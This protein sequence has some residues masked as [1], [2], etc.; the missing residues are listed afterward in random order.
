[1]AAA[2]PSDTELEER[3]DCDSTFDNVEEI[4]LEEKQWGYVLE[5]L[6]EE[7]G[8]H[9]ELEED[10]KSK[11]LGA[12]ENILN[13][14]DNL[15][16]LDLENFDT[17]YFNYF[18]IE[19]SK[20]DTSGID[21]SSRFSSQNQEDE[22][23]VN[24]DNTVLSQFSGLSLN[25]NESL[26]IP[27]ENMSRAEKNYK[28]GKEEELDFGSTAEYVFTKEEVEKFDTSYSN[29]SFT[30]EVK[31]KLLWDGKDITK[32]I[33]KSKIRSG[34]IWESVPRD[35]LLIEVEAQVRAL[36]CCRD[37]SKQIFLKLQEK[38]KEDLPFFSD[39][40]LS[41]LGCQGDEVTIL[42]S[43]LDSSDGAWAMVRPKGPILQASK[44]DTIE[45]TVKFYKEDFQKTEPMKFRWGKDS[46]LEPLESYL[47]GNLILKNEGEKLFIHVQ[48]PALPGGWAYFYSFMTPKQLRLSK[49]SVI[50]CVG[51]K[52]PYQTYGSVSFEGF[53]REKEER[54]GRQKSRELD[55]VSVKLVWSP[56]LVECQLAMAE[57][58]SVCFS[59][60]LDKSLLELESFLR[61]HFRYSSESRLVGFNAYMSEFRPFGPRGP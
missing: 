61:T 50:F 51:L 59:W 27:K 14:L 49:S 15:D 33:P 28:D 54:F 45:I 18:N 38:D 43:A 60:D 41:R 19:N 13:N 17:D 21:F 2:C 57:A 52:P 4:G 26:H 35:G 20:M 30:K 22:Y 46:V 10:W 53:R 6:G 31:I 29:I 47:R 8:R 58:R 5:E 44:D 36:L 11:A 1:M 34:V 32:R 39:T 40:S 9:E 7:G 3:G 12:S 48:D 56:M 24:Q 25:S 23:K 42:C 16:N 37:R 55:H